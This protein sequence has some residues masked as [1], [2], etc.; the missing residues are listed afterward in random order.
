VCDNRV[1]RLEESRAL[2]AG[3]RR[4]QVGCDTFEL[5]LDGRESLASSSR[6]FDGALA[7]I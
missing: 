5:G 2:G 3:Q 4:E 6:E 7:A 1:Q